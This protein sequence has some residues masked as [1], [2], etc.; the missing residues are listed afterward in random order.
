V[1]HTFAGKH[2]G[3][4]A[5]KRTAIQHLFSN[6]A[7]IPPAIRA[8]L[9]AEVSQIPPDDVPASEG[10]GPLAH[11]QG[12]TLNFR[13]FAFAPTNEHDV[14]SMF[15]AVASDLGFEIL[16]NRSAFPDCEARRRR[17]GGGRETFEK[18][19]IEYEFASSD[20]RKHKHPTTGCD[21]VVCWNSDWP[22][23]PIEVLELSK[24]ILDLDGWQFRPPP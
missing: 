6:R 21:L 12:R 7:R 11:R 4:G 14:V 19:L 9:E 10:Q 5:F 22:D 23:C 20:Y 17:R 13:A 3:Y 8:K 24:A 16:A 18:C 15:G 2:G 1:S